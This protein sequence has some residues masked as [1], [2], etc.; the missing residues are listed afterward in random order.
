MEPS[1]DLVANYHAH[2][3]RCKHASGTEREYVEKAIEGGFRIFGFSDHTPQPFPGDYV[4][5]VRMDLDELEGY[6]NTVLDLKREYSRDIEILLGL[7]VENYPGLFDPLYEI[8]KDYPIDYTIMG[9]HWTGGEP[10]GFISGRPT[11]DESVL[12]CYVNECIAAMA[13]GRILYLAHPDLLNF[14]GTDDIYDKHMLRLCKEAL[15]LGIPL[16]VN[17]LGIDINRHYPRK[18]FWELVGQTGNQV[19]IGT[20]AHLVKNVYRPDLVKRAYEELIIPCGLKMVPDN[21]LEIRK[22]F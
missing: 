14:Y 1:Y 12:E 20:D 13:S 18:H 8:L 16:E 7:E 22:I 5:S 9:Q 4:S 19:V 21:K 15:R 6:C 17:L 2:T 3:Y 10:E 11:E